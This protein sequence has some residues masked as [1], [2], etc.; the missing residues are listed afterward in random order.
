MG[1]ADASEM[2]EGRPLV[3]VSSAGPALGYEYIHLVGHRLKHLSFPPN[4][5]EE[6]QGR[7]SG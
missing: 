7:S 5:M 4:G 1:G 2:Q 6:K 3:R